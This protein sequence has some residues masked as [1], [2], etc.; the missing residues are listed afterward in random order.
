MLT[1]TSVETVLPTVTVRVDFTFKPD[2]FSGRKGE[3][4]SEWACLIME[5][6]LHGDADLTDD[7]EVVEVILT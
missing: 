7:H 5:K 4:L 3:T 2:E 1:G 6:M